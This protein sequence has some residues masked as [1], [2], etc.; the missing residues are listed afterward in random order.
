MALLEYKFGSVPKYTAI[1][2]F[3]SSGFVFCPNFKFVKQ[4]VKHVL[5]SELCNNK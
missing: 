2:L 3:S 4:D 5:H 1:R